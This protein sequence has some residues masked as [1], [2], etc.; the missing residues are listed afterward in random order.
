MSRVVWFGVAL[1]GCAS[2]AQQPPEA[3]AT[4]A[5][6][7]RAPQVTAGETT[8]PIPVADAAALS[9]VVTGAKALSDTL[10]TGAP[11]DASRA[12]NARPRVVVDEATAF[13]EDGDRVRAIDLATGKTR[14]LSG[15]GFRPYSMVAGSGLL[16]VSSGSAGNSADTIALRAADGHRA[17]VLRDFF[18]TAV[19]NGFLYGQEARTF[20]AYEAA[21][22][23][24]IWATTG[25]GQSSSGNAP[26]LAGTMLLQRFAD[27]GA[28]LVERVYAFDVRTGHTRWLQLSNTEPLGFQGAN[29]YLDSTWFPMQLD[30]YV[31]LTV[32]R[33]DTRTGSVL[34]EQT[35]APD[36]DRNAHPP[37][38]N[39]G[40]A[41]VAR[42]AGGFAYLQV[43][44]MWYRY[45]ADVAPESAH[46]SRFEGVDDI[47]A[48]FPNGALLV[49]AHGALALAREAGGRMELHRI[50][51]AS[52]YSK[53]FAR[54]D[55]VQYAVTAG[56]L[57]AFASDASTV[58]S[59]GAVPCAGE[60]TTID[61][62][63]ANV[64]VVCERGDGSARILTFDDPV[65]PAPT[66]APLARPQLPPP[67][68]YTARVRLFPIPPA[69]TYPGQWW[70]H[71][72]VPLPDGGVAFTLRPGSSDET[73]AIGRANA[74]GAVTVRTTGD[75]NEPVTPDDLV[76]DRHGTIWFNDARSAT[77]QRL[78][79]DGTVTSRLIGDPTPS[80]N[81]SIT[82]PPGMRRL[83]RRRPGTGIRLAIGPDGEAWYARSHPSR[84]IGRADGTTSF[85]IPDEVGDV[86]Q[87]RGDRNG[88][89]Y[90]ARSGVGHV[91]TGGKFTPLPLKPL[92]E[93]ETYPGVVV[94]PGTD[95][96]VWLTDG[97][98]VVHASARRELLRTAL[99]NVTVGSKAAAVGCDGA[100][101]VAETVSQI[102]RI[103]PDG[104]IDEL[105]VD[106][107]G[108]DG[109]TLGR[110]CRLWFAAGSNAHRQQIGTFELR[111]A[112]R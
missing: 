26:I 61:S 69:G 92:N 99:P 14:W 13:V 31:P 63:G 57:F 70:L 87:L 96:T 17:Y 34:D 38:E 24:R 101:Y 48:W 80:P 95:G 54:A 27:S 44:G 49:V 40:R 111:P 32:A 21:G 60:V 74:T 64:V 94:A 71:A 103:A 20:A 82:S 110:D 75:A 91:T 62:A 109:I 98:V 59:L 84:Q 2:A 30:N 10:V 16:F 47:V 73:G 25:G 50:A 3:T 23:R 37:N 28:I 105:P 52:G 1:A 55:G 15:H 8:Q 83:P 56:T 85:A 11:A 77:V 72:I 58:R 43:R 108:L 19:L 29:V 68:R 9:V 79:P 90:A 86:L 7:A 22:G 89:W 6:A 76:A 107:Y 100:L 4:R 97:S 102:A 35:Y 106:V 104:R 65:R 81:P 5:P 45:A 51:A 93:R 18:P 41:S 33:V 67:P 42:V 78:Q 36:P 88:F 53:A 66:A 46:P 112:P 12:P 39:P